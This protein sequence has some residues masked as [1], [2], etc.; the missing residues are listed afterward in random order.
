MILAVPAHKRSKIKPQY[1][2]DVSLDNYLQS[3][4]QKLLWVA[5]LFGQDWMEMMVILSVSDIAL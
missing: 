1:I 2:C 5:S 4:P 3:E